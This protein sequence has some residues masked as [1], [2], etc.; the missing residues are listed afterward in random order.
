M[1]I[2]DRPLH[3]VGYFRLV[4]VLCPAAVSLAV[5]VCLAVVKGCSVDSR[6]RDARDCA[7]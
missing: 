3:Y 7:N 2:F 4:G 5:P 6:T 1:E